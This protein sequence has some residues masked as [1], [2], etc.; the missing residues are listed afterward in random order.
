MVFSAVTGYHAHVYY[1]PTATRDRAESVRA[2]L[3]ANFPTVRL[4]RWHDVPV[5]PHPQAM[6]QVAFAVD[7]LSTLLPWLMLNRQGLDILVHPETGRERADH[8]DHAAWLGHILPVDLSKLPP[9]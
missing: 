6:F 9:D 4:G 1:E 8:S 5:G 3:E 7:L 2:G